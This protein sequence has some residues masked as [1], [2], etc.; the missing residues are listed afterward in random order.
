MSVNALNA[1]NA[2]SGILPQSP[3]QQQRDYFSQ[4]QQSLGSG[5]LTGAQQ[6]FN[7][8]QQLVQNGQ[9]KNGGQGGG[10]S[11]LQNDFAALGQALQSGDTTA[12]QKAFATLQQDLQKVRQAHHH[13]RHHGPQDA[14]ANGATSPTQSSTTDADGDG[15]G[16]NAAGTTVNIT[17]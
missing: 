3:F 12:A 9:A 11:T 13:H 7:S 4:L 8:L 15:D 17:A 14:S 2:S 5:D 16:S 10:N 1:L 6:A